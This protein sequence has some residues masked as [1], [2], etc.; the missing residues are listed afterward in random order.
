MENQLY[1]EVASLL[2]PISTPLIAQIVHLT[3]FV[4]SHIISSAF[5]QVFTEYVAKPGWEARAAAV[6]PSPKRH[7]KGHS[8]SGCYSELEQTHQVGEFII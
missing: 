8:F 5:V 1:I 4:P 3:L 7:A 2:N 6:W